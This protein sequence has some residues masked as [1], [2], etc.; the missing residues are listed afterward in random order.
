[1][2]ESTTAIAGQP[3]FGSDGSQLIA[4]AQGGLTPYRDDIA[5]ADVPFQTLGSIGA[6]IGKENV[7]IINYDK[8]LIAQRDSFISR[9]KQAFRPAP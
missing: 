5:R 6:E 3:T 1:M 9:W 8:N 7:L 2:P 4:F